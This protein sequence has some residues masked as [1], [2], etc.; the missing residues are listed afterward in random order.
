M[1]LSDKAKGK[2]RA[3]EPTNPEPSLSTSKE[4]VFRFTEGIPDLRLNINA[5]DSVKGVKQKVGGELC[6]IHSNHMANVTASSTTTTGGGQAASPHPFWTT[7]HR[8]YHAIR[9]VILAGGTAEAS[10]G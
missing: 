1:P 2:Q 7:A 10:I 3:Q 5:T 4:L 6:W 9:V 8:W